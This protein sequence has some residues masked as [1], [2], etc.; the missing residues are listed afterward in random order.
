MPVLSQWSA[1]PGLGPHLHFRC[2]CCLKR[3]ERSCCCHR[4]AADQ[5]V[6]FRHEPNNPHDPNAVAITTLAGLSLGYISKD[7]TAHFMQACGRTPASS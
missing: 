2:H 1:L 5:P 7:K 4:P 6:V 3:F